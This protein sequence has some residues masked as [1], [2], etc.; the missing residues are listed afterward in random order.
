MP[1]FV[2][3]HWFGKI[4]DVVQDAVAGLHLIRSDPEPGEF[5]LHLTELKLFFVEGDPIVTAQLEV[6]KGVVEVSFNVVV[7]EKHIV[8]FHASMT[9]F[10]VPGLNR[11]TWKNG[12]LVECVY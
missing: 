6:V 11:D 8:H 7:I 5:H 3:G 9:L 2:E 1:R 10:Q 4:L 12:T